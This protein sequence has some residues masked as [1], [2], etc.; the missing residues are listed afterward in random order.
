[1]DNWGKAGPLLLFLGLLTLINAPFDWVSLGLTRGLLRRGLEKGGWAP[2][3]FGLLDA[4]VAV[5]VIAL[6]AAAMVLSVQVFDRMAERGGG[7]AVLLLPKD[8]INHISHNQPDPNFAWICVLLLST[9]IP[10]LLN[11]AIGGASLLRWF[12]SVTARLLKSLEPGS[13]I[14]V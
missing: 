8:L 6:L 13:T 10:S 7:K 9:M 4:A 2:F 14:G 3:V 12:P 11:L 1:M 5:I